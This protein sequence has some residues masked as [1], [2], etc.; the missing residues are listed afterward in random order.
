MALAAPPKEVAAMVASWTWSAG[1]LAG[2]AA[3]RI[4]VRCIHGSST[5]FL[6]GSPGLRSPGAAERVVLDLLRAQHGQR[7][8]CSC[9]G[10]G[11]RP[12]AG[13]PWS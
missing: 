6:V 5:S 11:V 9:A 7:L 10:P 13:R 8:G 12:A 2:H 1:R 3:R 4:E